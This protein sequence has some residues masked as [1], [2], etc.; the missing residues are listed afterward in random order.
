MNRALGCIV[1]LAVG[2]GLNPSTAVLAECQPDLSYLAP[3]IPATSV[4]AL[5]SVR[6]TI[7]ETKIETVIE[8]IRAQGMGLADAASAMLAQSDSYDQQLAQFEDCVN[9]AATREAAPGIMSGLKARQY[10]GLPLDDGM[11]GSCVKGYV[12]VDWGKLANSETAVQV[13]CNANKK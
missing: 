11:L 5:D 1:V 4:A 2:I 10:A 9:S 13:A 3:Q 7:L 6:T 12:V 8:A